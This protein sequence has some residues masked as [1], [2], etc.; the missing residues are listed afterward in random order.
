MVSTAATVGICGLFVEGADRKS[1]LLFE[2]KSAK[3]VKCMI[4]SMML[5]DRHQSV[6]QNRVPKTHH[7]KVP[8]FERSR[9]HFLLEV[10]TI[11][12]IILL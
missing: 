12:R 9:H 6:I 10:T 4:M 1:L 5:I 3:L 8:A 2:Y 7:Q 11:R